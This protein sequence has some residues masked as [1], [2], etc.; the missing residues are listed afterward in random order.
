MAVK[1]IDNGF[2]EITAR[3]ARRLA[4]GSLPAYGREKLV[5]RD[6]RHYW[7]TQTIVDRKA[8]WSIRETAWRL[9]DGRAVLS[10][11]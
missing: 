6:G 5:V 11:E 7:L 10:I 9:V 4:G 8:V 2:W 1:Y 3:E